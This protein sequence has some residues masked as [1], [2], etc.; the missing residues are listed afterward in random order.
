MEK[1]F[2]RQLQGHIGLNS[3]YE[4][5]IQPSVIENDMIKPKGTYNDVVYN[6]IDI[7]NQYNC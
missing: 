5:I 7:E 3:V 2:T 1:I 6:G 4:S